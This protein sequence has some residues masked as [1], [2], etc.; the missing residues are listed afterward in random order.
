[1]RAANER[2]KT[3]LIDKLLTSTNSRL[4]KSI[5]TLRQSLC[6]LH[7][8]YDDLLLMRSNRQLAES[9]LIIVRLRELLGDEFDQREPLRQLNEALLAVD[10]LLL[11]YAI[12]GDADALATASL[13]LSRHLELGDTPLVAGSAAVCTQLE[14]ELCESQQYCS[15]NA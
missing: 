15:V 7:L 12:I 5:A 3:K 11:K 13:K 10:E 9:M 8:S 4:H 14:C 1:M 2:L 6:D